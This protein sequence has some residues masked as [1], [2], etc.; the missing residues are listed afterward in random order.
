M[1]RFPILFLGIAA[2]ALAAACGPDGDDDDD[3]AS[4]NTVSGLIALPA[5]ATGACGM[6]AIDDDFDP[7]NGPAQ[8]TN[9]SFL[10][11]FQLLSGSSVTFSYDDVADGS[12]YIWAYVDA[13]ISDSDPAG[14]CEI[15]GAPTPGDHFGFFDTG[16]SIPPAPNVE[17]PHAAGTSYD[18]ALYELP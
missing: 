3:N 14:D 16:L 8:R 13:D 18:F 11:G 15:A 4:N 10:W 9:G 5:D 2:L 6:I 7:S 17:V 12:Y 1:K